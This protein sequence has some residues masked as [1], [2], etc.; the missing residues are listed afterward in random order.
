MQLPPVDGG[1]FSCEQFRITTNMDTNMYVCVCTGVGGGTVFF[2]ILLFGGIGV[3]GGIYLKKIK[4]HLCEK[5]TFL[6]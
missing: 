1:V 4:P 2:L 3:G 6:F 5:V